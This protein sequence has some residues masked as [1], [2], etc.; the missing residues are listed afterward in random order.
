MEYRHYRNDIGHFPNR[1]ENSRTI[2]H[3]LPTLTH[4]QPTQ[5]GIS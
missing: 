4:G 2:A 5:P 1:L 3:K